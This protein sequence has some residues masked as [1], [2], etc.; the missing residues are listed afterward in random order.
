MSA[1]VPHLFCFGLGYSAQRLAAAVAEAGGAVSGTSRSADQAAAGAERGYTMHVFDGS[2]GDPLWLKGATHVLLSVP[3]G[4]DGDPVLRSFGPVL[5]DLPSLAW[6]GYLST[7]GVYGNTDGAWV[8]ETA[9]LNP[10]VDRSQRRAQAEAGWQALAARHHL[11][12][13]IFRLAGIYGPGRNVLKQARAGKARR[14]IKPGHQ[15]SRIHVD[16]IARVLEASIARPN[17]QTPGGAVYNVCDDEPA[18]P[19][20]VT[21]FACDLLGIDPPDPMP[22]D[23]AAKG[24]SPMGLSFWNDNRKVR[25]NRIKAELGVQLAY[26]TYRDGLRAIYASDFADPVE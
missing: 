4:P 24:M 5:A 6:L 1:S 21:S 16:D 8:D 18:A 11:P 9:A 2:V 20:D 13:H 15:F 19:A 25:N 7:T 3:P 14:I 23:E 26:P 10:D 22:F 12:L 17:T